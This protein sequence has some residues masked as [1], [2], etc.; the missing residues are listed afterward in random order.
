MP[1]WT[2]TL[3]NRENILF[4]GD[5]A[6]IVMPV[7]YEGIYYAMKSGQFAAHALI[8][9]NP[10]LYKKHWDSR[11]RTRFLFMRTIR[12]HLFGDD[13]NIEKW[14]ALHKRPDVQELAVQLW[15][16]K[17]HGRKSILMAYIKL[18]RHLLK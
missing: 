17:K 12:Q 9:R 5:A 15:L 14:V 1:A 10:D 7:I 3:F 6:G 13:K 18:F 8:D 11:F 2:G 16:N 4:T